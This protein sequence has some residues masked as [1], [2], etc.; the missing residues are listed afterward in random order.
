MWFGDKKT[1]ILDGVDFK[2]FVSFTS[3]ATALS[4]ALKSD[5]TFGITFLVLLF[6]FNLQSKPVTP[7]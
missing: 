7:R 3:Y 6:T 1:P 4:G 2:N 5:I